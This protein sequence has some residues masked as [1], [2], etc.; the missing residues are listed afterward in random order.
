MQYFRTVKVYHIFSAKQLFKFKNW[1]Y[2]LGISPFGLD[3][4]CFGTLNSPSGACPAIYIIIYSYISPLSKQKIYEFC[5]GPVFFS[6][7]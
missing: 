3:E 5:S 4:G 6:E 7:A 2:K 1:E